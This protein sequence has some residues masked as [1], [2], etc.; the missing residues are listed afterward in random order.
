MM[1]KF[2]GLFKLQGRL[3]QN[4]GRKSQSLVSGLGIGVMSEFP[5][6]SSRVSGNS[7]QVLSTIRRIH[8]VNV[9]QLVAYCVEGEALSS[10][11]FHAQWVD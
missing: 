4:F 7:G 2:L 11:R 8:H 5:Q 9:V 1:L 6:D 10:L 3:C